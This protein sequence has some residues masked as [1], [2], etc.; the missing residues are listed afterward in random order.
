MCGKR[1]K[2]TGFKSG[3]F[4]DFFQF[5]ESERLEVCE[6]S[7]RESRRS[8]RALIG[9]VVQFVADGL[10]LIVEVL[11]ESFREFGGV[12][13]VGQGRGGR[14]TEQV[15]HGGKQGFGAGGFTDFGAVV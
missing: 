11:G 3:F 12:D 13:V 9:N 5:R 15:I 4:D 6:R 10:D 14:A 8:V 2:V 7:A 1:V